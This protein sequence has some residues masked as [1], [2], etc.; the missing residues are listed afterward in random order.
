ML[1]WRHYHTQLSV[2]L[3]LKAFTDLNWKSNLVHACDQSGEDS[4]H[5]PI[6]ISLLSSSQ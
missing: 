6:F 1:Y 2:T 4:I 5:I 3:R